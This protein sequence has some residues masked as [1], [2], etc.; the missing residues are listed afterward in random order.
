LFY[1]DYVPQVLASRP[2]RDKKE[3]VLD[4]MAVPFTREENINIQVSRCNGLPLDRIEVFA[5]AKVSTFEEVLVLNRRF[6]GRTPDLLIVTSP[7]NVRRAQMD[8]VRVLPT[9]HRTVFATPYEELPEHWWPSREAARDLLLELD[10]LA[11]SCVDGR[12]TGPA[13]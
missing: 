5:K 6:A 2:A 10:K 4:R 1:Q 8:L 7:Y 3:H 12:F 13:T 11:F 9:A